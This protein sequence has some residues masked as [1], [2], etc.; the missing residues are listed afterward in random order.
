MYLGILQL[1][2]FKVLQLLDTEQVHL[3]APAHFSPKHLAAYR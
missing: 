1:Q 3:R 2:P